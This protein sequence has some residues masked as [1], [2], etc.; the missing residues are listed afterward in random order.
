MR[1]TVRTMRPPM[2][3]MFEWIRANHPSLFSEHVQAILLADPQDGSSPLIKAVLNRNAYGSQ[4]E[5]FQASTSTLLDREFPGVFIRAPRFVSADGDICA[6]H[7]DEVVG[8][9]NGMVIG[10]TFHPELSP[11]RGFHKWIIENAKV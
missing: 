1:K 9:K 8:V 4:Y 10:L 6:T 5:S 11:D 7:G 2:P 3:G